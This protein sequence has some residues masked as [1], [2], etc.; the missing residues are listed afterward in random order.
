[1]SAVDLLV[2]QSGQIEDERHPSLEPSDRMFK[3]GLAT[4]VA[5]LISA[6]ATF[7]ILT[8]LT[9]ILPRNDVVFVALLANVVLIIAMVVVIAQQVVGLYA[10]WR[11]KLA[12]ARLH[13]RIVALFSIIAALPA[14]LLAVGA[15]VSF[16]RSLD[17]WF[18]D[19]IRTIIEKSVDVARTYVDE[20]GRVIRTDAV[21]MARDL[22]AAVKA[23]NRPVSQ[24]RGLILSQAG[25][26]ELP[27]AYVIDGK[28]APV[29]RALED[30]RLPFKQ[31]TMA[32]MDEARDGLIP[33]SLSQEDNR[34]SAIARLETPEERYIYVSR[35][36]DPLVIR[37]LQ[38][39]E[40]NAAE[41]TLLRR[42]RGGLKWAHGLMYLTISMTGLLA[43]I[44]A[45]M[46]FAGRFV[47][48]IR[49]LIGA[50]QEVSR[51]N[52]NI[53]LPEKR[54][55]GDLRRLSQ[56]FNTMTVE[57]ESQRKT[58]MS[59]NELL[60]ERRRFM[61]AV[62]SGVTA[63]VIGLD[64]DDKITL[65]SRAATQLLGLE[66]AALVGQPISD[67]LPEFK[68]I[69]DD[70][71]NTP[72]KQRQQL[73]L[74]R[75]VNEEER[76]FAVRVTRE[77]A[78]E[79]EVGSVVTFDDITELV[80]AQRTSAWA[81]VAQRIAHEIKNPLT[82][83]QLSAER[84]RRKYGKV[85]VDDRETFDKLTETIE[86]QAGHIKGMV[87]E[88]A[89]FARMPKPEM[90]MSDLRDAVSE[91]VVLFR[92]AHPKVT[93]A[94]D[95]PSQV[96]KSSFDRR[97]ISQA[98]TNLVKNAT[99]SVETAA[100]E[101]GLKPEGFKGK[102][103]TRMQVEDNCVSIEVIDNGLGLP[104][105][106]RARLLEPYVTTKGNKGTGL[107]LAMVQKITEQHGGTLSLE[108]AP[109]TSDPTDG[110]G[111]LMRIKLPLTGPTPP[112][113][114]ADGGNARTDDKTRKEQPASA[115][116]MSAAAA[117]GSNT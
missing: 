1:M 57:L 95:I 34:I 11:Q 73:E 117:S 28:G 25:L 33:L 58:L 66:E 109:Q 115:I 92:E 105:Q 19:R 108:D 54:G 27:A 90:S 87:D 96:V 83:I 82:P 112:A 42:T 36:L 103:T 10:A 94:L 55:E 71:A 61:E 53:S 5:A 79:G 7:M 18:S 102:V 39:T 106:Q 74:T 37:H 14:I 56:T 51:G 45:G 72:L 8:G 93:F 69:L 47:A 52:L 15:T 3:I 30:R 29:L 40:Q 49:R 98:L 4:V 62:L 44:W 12:G 70:S 91:P 48:P 22:A 84:I 97:L 89:S 88:F 35:P 24:M 17:S 85:I 107:G 99:E 32:A 9:P 80:T 6:F 50:A 63:G 38:R 26:R 75:T 67:V 113:H 60:Q 104:K 76:T 78:S 23:D 41:Y 13:V 64:A 77:A 46:W 43:A 101:K 2:H 31:P 16:S 100:A 116:A 59:A 81:D 86:R 114:V 110:N 65:V 68:G 20:H 111:A 21:N